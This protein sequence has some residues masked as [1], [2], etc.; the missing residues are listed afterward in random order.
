MVNWIK[1]KIVE[2]K[3][4]INIQEWKEEWRVKYFSVEEII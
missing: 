4:E 1:I 3:K 2:R